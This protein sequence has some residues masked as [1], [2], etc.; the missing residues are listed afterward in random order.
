MYYHDS[1]DDLFVAREGDIL[2]DK[3]GRRVR[4]CRLC[5][6]LNHV[7]FVVPYDGSVDPGGYCYRCRRKHGIMDV[8]D[9]KRYGKIL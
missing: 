3:L 9:A 6:S 4:E 7:K 1:K 5:G 2:I 8:K